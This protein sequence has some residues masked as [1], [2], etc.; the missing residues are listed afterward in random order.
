MPS[1][2]ILVVERMAACTAISSTD[3]MDTD[4]DDFTK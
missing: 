3:L 1:S 4:V 2:Q